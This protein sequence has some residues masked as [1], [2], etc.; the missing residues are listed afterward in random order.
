MKTISI[1]LPD[2]VNMDIKEVKFIIASRLY[3]QGQLSLGEAAEVVGVSKRTF[4][5]LLGDYGVSVFNYG[6]EEL[7]SDYNNA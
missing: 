6:P 3:E 2:S 1:K 4:I 7:E 5:E